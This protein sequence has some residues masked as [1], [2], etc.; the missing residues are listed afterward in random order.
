MLVCKAGISWK[1]IP[2]VSLVSTG[3]KFSRSNFIGILAW[4]VEIERVAGIFTAVCNLKHIQNTR[5]V[6]REIVVWL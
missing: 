6:G 2:L 4:A 3:I 1:T 5:T